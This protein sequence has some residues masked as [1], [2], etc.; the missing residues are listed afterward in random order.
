MRP[1]HL[2]E[3]PEKVLGRL[4]DVDATGVVGEVVAQR[5]P[6]ELLAEDVDLVQEEDDA[7][8]YEPPRVDDRVEQEETLHHSVLT[9]LLAM[10]GPGSRERWMETYLAALL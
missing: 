7:R 10:S 6:P 9:D 3:P 4:V 5:R 8:P 1:V 2:V